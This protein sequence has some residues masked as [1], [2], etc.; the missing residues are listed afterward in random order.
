MWYCIRQLCVAETSCSDIS[1]ESSSALKTVSS[2]AML[3]DSL[4]TSIGI[5]VMFSRIFR[6][7]FIR[8]SMESL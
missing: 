3:V 5:A 1:V 6:T 4:L 7:F 2:G 8:V